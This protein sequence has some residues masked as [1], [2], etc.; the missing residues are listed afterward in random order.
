MRIISPDDFIDLYYKSKQRGLKFLSSKLNPNHINRTKSAFNDTAIHSSNW[1][2]IPKVQERWN[3]LVT[4][5]PKTNY[6]Q[7]TNEHY[8]K[9]KKDIQMLS[10]GS[11]TCTAELEFA[12]YPSIK[13][14]ICVD[15]AENRINEAK[16]KAKQQNINSIDF[17]IADVHSFDLAENYYDIIFFNSSLHHFKNLE[18]FLKKIKISL[19]Q[20][21]F[22]I[23]NEYVGPNRLQYPNNQ[24]KAINEAIKLIPKKYRIR[25]KSNSFKNRYYG[26]GILRM[27]IADPSECIESEK[28]LP[29]IHKDFQ[30]VEEKIIGGN[31]LM[32]AFKDI[33]HNFIEINKE[34]EKI[35][36]N[37]F[38]FEDEYLEN[39]KSDFIF[40]IYK[41]IN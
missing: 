39:N 17:K 19:K 38:R 22:L 32:S 15:I 36:D 23:I 3:L 27:I 7:Y 35:L 18:A 41:K 6:I 8:L 31:I 24:I 33:S 12:R 25:F 30:I 37:L 26:S 4:G 11:G 10:L 20:D 14:I 16:E 28:I 40:G 13:K 1:W 2:I 29:L 34:K 5:N 21:G 9:D